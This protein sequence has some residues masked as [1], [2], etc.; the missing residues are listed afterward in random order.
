MILGNL[1]LMD[2]LKLLFIKFIASQHIA[3]VSPAA[4]LSK[5]KMKLFYPSKLYR[6]SHSSVI[7]LDCD[8]TLWPDSGP[9]CFLDE[10]FL[11]SPR[12]ASILTL[13][14]QYDYV[15]FVTNQSFFARLA[16]YSIRDLVRFFTF[17][18]KLAHIFQASAVFICLHHPEAKNISLRVQCDSRKPHPRMIWMAQSFVNVNYKT[19]I[20]LGD[21]I[22]DIYAG[23]KSGLKNCL[24][25]Y[26]EAFFL[27]NFEMQNDESLEAVFFKVVVF[28]D[29]N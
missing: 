28:G 21:R 29:G 15:F 22:S 8:G 23:D 18:R 25:L 9:G 20:V 24:A 1:Q 6:R 17:Y 2:S 10:K 13:S 19:S 14:K 7:F 4:L 5:L 3:Y 16:T 26:N 12:L 11:G 27:Q